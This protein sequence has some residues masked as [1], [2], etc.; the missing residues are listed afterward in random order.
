MQDYLPKCCREGWSQ[1][2][3]SGWPDLRDPSTRSYRSCLR[4]LKRPLS[5][6]TLSSL[7]RYWLDYCP[8]PR[9][10]FWW[11]L[12]K[13][14]LTFSS[15]PLPLCSWM[16]R[17]CWN[18]RSPH[19]SSFSYRES[20]SSFTF[21]V[22]PHSLALIFRSYLRVWSRPLPVKMAFPKWS[23]VCTLPAAWGV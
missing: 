22:G 13:A 18:L 15:S 14:P 23:L 9:L 11:A 2:S 17:D 19:Q 16:T 7:D 5:S 21:A 12:P 6:R 3:S 20:S 10:P 1:Q 8:A 4:S